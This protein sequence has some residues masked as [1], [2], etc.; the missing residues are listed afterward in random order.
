MLALNAL[1]NPAHLALARLEEQGK[2]KA[3][4]TQNI[5][6]CTKK[7]AA[8]MCW[9][10]TGAFGATIV[11]NA[12]SFTQPNILPKHRGVPLCSCG[13]II[14]PDVVLYEEALSSSILQKS[15][16]AIEKADMLIVGGTSLAV[17]P[18][19][20]L[21]DYFHGRHL[22]VVNISPLAVDKRADLVISQKIGSVLGQVV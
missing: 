10:C 17:Y 21:V 4:V 12:A 19:A 8:G 16:E 1:P 7:R 9:N 18:A 11:Y 3:V 15:V 5:D 14:K 20:G 2:L 13:G 6:G 22:V